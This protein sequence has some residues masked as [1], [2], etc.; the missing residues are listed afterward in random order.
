MPAGAGQRVEEMMQDVIGISVPA[1]QLGVGETIDLPGQNPEPL[2]AGIGRG[3]V[4]MKRLVDPAIDEIDARGRPKR[5]SAV[6]QPAANI[7][8]RGHRTAGMSDRKRR[9]VHLLHLLD[10]VLDHV[11][12]VSMGNQQ[13]IGLRHH[14]QIVQ[15]CNGKQ[16]VFR[17]Q[18]AVLHIDRQHIAETG[19]AMLVLLRSFMELRP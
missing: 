4:V 15:A 17:A 14:D 10:Q 12:P 2:E 8:E 7:V 11:G 16:P 6:E 9:P 18:I 3:A 1:E 13:G 5:K 19:V